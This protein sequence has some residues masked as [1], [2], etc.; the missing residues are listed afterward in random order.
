MSD[1]KNGLRNRQKGNAERSSGMGNLWFKVPEGVELFKIEKG[2]NLVDILPF[3]H[4]TDK[5]ANVPRAED[6][7]EK[8]DINYVLIVNVHRNIGPSKSQVICPRQFGKTCPIC[9]EIDRLKDEGQEYEDFK[10]LC[11]S[12]RVLYNVRDCN[13]RNAP[14]QLWEG[15]NKN[16]ESKLAVRVERESKRKGEIIFA[17]YEEGYS[18]SFYGTEKTWNKRKFIEPD[19][20]AFEERTKQPGEAILDETIQLDTLINVLTY[21]DISDLFYGKSDDEDTSKK[22]KKPAKEESPYTDDSE[23]EKNSF[24]EDNA[25]DE[26]P[27]ETP[28]EEE[29]T[30]TRKRTPAKEESEDTGEKKCSQGL[31]FGKDCDS[32]PKKC[33]KC[34]EDEWKECSVAKRKK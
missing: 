11:Y 1:R 9:E 21:D 3:T 34:S 18:I 4:G 32:D 31:T 17:D 2:E 28:V 12:V 19:D 5:F 20:W 22:S 33:Q 16:I 14:I 29:K 15:S 7:I 8:G 30:S 25:P 23:D 27:E 13:G 24:D 6:Q 26:T 10:D